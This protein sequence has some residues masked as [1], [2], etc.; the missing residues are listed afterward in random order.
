MLSPRGAVGLVVFCLL[1]LCTDRIIIIASKHPTSGNMDRQEKQKKH[2]DE[3]MMKTMMTTYSS[4][5]IG[6][7]L[8]KMLQI[9]GVSEQREIPSGSERKQKNNIWK[10]TDDGDDD[11]DV[12]IGPHRCFGFAAVLNADHF[13]ALWFL[14]VLFKQ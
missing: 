11:D 7:P 5:S 12:G 4:S 1:C 9:F 13:F 2:A 6:Q 3:D 10:A 14:Q 8:H